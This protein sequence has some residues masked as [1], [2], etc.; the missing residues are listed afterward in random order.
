MEAKCAVFDATNP[1]AASSVNAIEKMKIF[2][3]NNH[4]SDL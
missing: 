3:A 1:S 4:L 2:E